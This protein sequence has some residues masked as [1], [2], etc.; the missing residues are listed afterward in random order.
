MPWRHS[1]PK[2]VGVLRGDAEDLLLALT[3]EQFV[4][5]L[6]VVAGAE[7]YVEELPA[8][9]LDIV[10]DAPRPDYG[11]VVWQ[12]E[13]LLQV[14][15]QVLVIVVPQERREGDPFAG[16]TAPGGIEAD[17]ETVLGS[18]EEESQ[19]GHGGPPGAV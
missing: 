9:A 18:V 8:P 2:D 6:A 15:A 16:V 13:V 4:D 19:F 5:Q 12:V 11:P 1:G 7:D 3:V 17:G 10:F 14:P